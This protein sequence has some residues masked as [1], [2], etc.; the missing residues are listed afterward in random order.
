MKFILDNVL[1]DE[2]EVNVL[3]SRYGNNTTSYIARDCK[4]LTDV[5]NNP[6]Y[7]HIFLINKISL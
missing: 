7:K 1:R 4:I 5:C 3:Y 2:K 6:H